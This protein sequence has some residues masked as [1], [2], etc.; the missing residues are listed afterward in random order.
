MEDAVLAF[1]LTTMLVGIPV[2]AFTATRMF[3][4][5]LAFKEKQLEAANRSAALLADRQRA[6][7][8][9]LQVRVQVLERIATDR[10]QQLAHEIETLREPQRN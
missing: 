10:S 7:V 1:V 4:Q 6:N 8:E 3:R 9:D 5:W 2:I